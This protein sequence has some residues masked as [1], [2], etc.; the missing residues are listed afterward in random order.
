MSDPAGFG[1]N[2]AI[3]FSRV[4]KKEGST[5]GKVYFA[6]KGDLIFGKEASGE[7]TGHFGRLKSLSD[8]P[9]DKRR[10]GFRRVRV[11]GGPVGLAL[12]RCETR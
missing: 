8:L 3:L 12:M 5:L 11:G 4:G 7:A 6:K 1:P 10:A 9:S 2:N